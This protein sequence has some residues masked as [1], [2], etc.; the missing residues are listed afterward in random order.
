MIQ[1]QVS[2]CGTTLF[3]IYKYILFAECHHTPS[4]ITLA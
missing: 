2:T 4:P 3:D 1:G